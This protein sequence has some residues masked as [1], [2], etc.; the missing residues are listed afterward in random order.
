MNKTEAGFHLL[1][2]ISKVDGKIEKAESNVLLDFLEKSFRQPIDLIK[3]QAF[4]MAYPMDD[5]MDHFIETAEQFFKI[6]TSNER[7]KI[8]QFA[9]KICM[10]DNKMENGENKFINALYDAWGLD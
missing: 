7:N 2:I 10:A 1:M 3:E 4:L 6:S 8:L 9:M 5:M